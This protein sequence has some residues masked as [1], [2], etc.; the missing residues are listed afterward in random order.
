MTLVNVYQK[1]DR[2]EKFQLVATVD[3]PTLNNDVALNDA[4]AMTQ[5][6]DCGWYES[7]N[8]TSHFNGESCRSTSVGD[9]I[10]TGIGFFRVDSCGFSKVD[11]DDVGFHW[12]DG[13][14]TLLEK[15]EA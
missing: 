8:I 6:I 9:L 13:T 5:N 15:E 4:Y 1:H 12:K 10:Q 2:E 14:I 3:V 11:F 7:D